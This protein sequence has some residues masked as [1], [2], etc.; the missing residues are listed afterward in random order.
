MNYHRILKRQIK[1][2]L[3]RNP[4]IDDNTANILALVSESYSQ[5]DADRELLENTMEVSSKELRDSNQTLQIQQ[6]ELEEAYEEL[7]ATRTKLEETEK[8]AALSQELQRTVQS[9]YSAQQNIH[10]AQNSAKR[11][12]KA[13]LGPPQSI[14][15]HCPDA[16]IY[17]K[18]VSIVSGDF[19]WFGE[20]DDK[21]III[22]ADCTGHGVAG[23]FM[24]ILG[25]V[26]LNEIIYLNREVNPAKILYQ[27]DEKILQNLQGKKNIPAE[28]IHNGMDIA[29][30]V[31][32]KNTNKI[33]FSGAKIPLYSIKN[34]EISE[35]KGSIFPIGGHKFR[36]EKVFTTQTFDFEKG[37]I[38]Y[39]ASDGFQDQFGGK[40]NKKYLKK[41]FREFLLEISALPMNEQEQ[42]IKQELLT[43]KGDSRQIDDVLVLGI[44][45]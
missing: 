28:K 10:A 33:Q 29:I 43:W 19:Y 21:K 24:T 39:M 14:T 20:L 1:K 7:F 32:D 8:I 45:L 35:I 30:L 3:G 42:I 36:N 6:A 44:K 9:L 34:N 41:R 27:L 25:C 26:L 13:I 4:E 18:P 22:A 40:E 2:I 5:F 15:Q 37:D 17:Y 38:I 11:I 16:T 12:Q 23:A 31:I